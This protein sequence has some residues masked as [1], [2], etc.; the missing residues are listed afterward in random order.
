[1]SEKEKLGKS[2]RGQKFVPVATAE[3]VQDQMDEQKPFDKEGAVSIEM[4]FAARGHRDPVMHA[5]M[6]AYTL[7]RRATY[8][9]W[10][11]IFK[12]F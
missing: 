11:A 8:A 4:W 6:R 10:D 3:D 5:A 2:Y 9:D 12:D 7:V 1:M